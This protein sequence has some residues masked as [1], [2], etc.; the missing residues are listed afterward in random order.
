[1]ND[2]YICIRI[3]HCKVSLKSLM[4]S[5][6]HVSTSLEYLDLSQC[7]SMQGCVSDLEELKSLSVLNIGFTKI[8][9][10]GIFDIDID[11][12]RY[13]HVICDIVYICVCLFFLSMN[14]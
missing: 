14:V 8:K 1:M 6:K 7:A 12:D 5:L 10:D 9:I 3:C 11:I 4:E 13:I 2:I